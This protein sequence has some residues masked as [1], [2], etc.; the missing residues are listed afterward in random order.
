MIVVTD[1]PESMGMRRRP[2]P[3]GQDVWFGS[4]ARCEMATVRLNGRSYCAVGEV[5]RWLLA[6]L[7]S[8]LVPNGRQ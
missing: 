5:P 8:R 1:T 3:A 4:F 7:L 6:D 2:G